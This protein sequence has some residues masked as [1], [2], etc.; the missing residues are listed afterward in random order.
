MS[1]G[2][3]MHVR[4]CCARFS[5]FGMLGNWRGRLSLKRSIFVKWDLQP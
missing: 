2:L 1:F 3:L 4:F 5:S